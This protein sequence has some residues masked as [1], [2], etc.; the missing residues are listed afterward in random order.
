MIRV[1]ILLGV[2]FLWMAVA[3]GQFAMPAAAPVTEAVWVSEVK[4]AA[5]GGEFRMALMLKHP[6]GWHSYYQNSGGIEQSLAI[7]WALPQ[8]VSAGPIQSPVPEVKDG[9]SGKSFVHSGSPVFLIDITLPSTLRPGQTVTLG[10]EATWQICAE[11]CLNEHSSLSLVLPVGPVLVKDPAVEECFST[12]RVHQAASPAAGWS[13][14]AYS[15]GAN[16]VLRIEPGEKFSGTFTDFIPDQPFVRAA[17]DGGSI[18][19]DGKAWHLELPRAT[20]DAFKTPITQGDS[21]SGILIGPRAIAIPMTAITRPPAVP[22]PW[23]SYF[24]VLCGMALGGLL[25]NLMPCVFPVIGL[26]ILGF[27]QQSGEDRKKI[28]VHGL[29]FSL[30]VWVSFGVLSG[31]LFVARAAAGADSG[32]LGWGYQL[33]NPWVVMVLMLL[34]FVLALNLFGVFEMGI[35]ATSL[36]GSLQSKQGFAG[37]FFSGVLATV[38]ATPCSAPFLGVAL[39]AAIAL[40]GAQFFLAFAAMATG[41][42]LPYLALSIFP[43]VLGLLPRPGPWM[44]SFKQAMSFLLFATAGY[45]LWVYA[46]LIDLDHLPGPIFGLSAIAVAAWIYG[47]WNLP[48]RTRRTRGIAFLLVLGFSAGGVFLAKPPPPSAITWEPWSE[49]RVEALLEDGKPVYIDF[50]AQWCATCQANKLRAYTPQVVALMQAK[51]VVALRAD[52]TKPNPGIE[53]ALQHLG[54]TAIPVN[55]L[56]APDREP[57]ILPALL[58][59]GDLLE[60]LEKL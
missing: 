4:T 18:R 59:P 34:M 40:P 17:S 24:T 10:A 27:V 43:Q 7:Q 41:L 48:H 39:G 31:I 37:S 32:S 28:A 58:S 25:L 50:T 57:V 35:A 45:L 23:A 3:C 6:A 8:G 22:L 21:L 11:S 5:P 49:S 44:E 38:V 33:Q 30:G 15:S 60:A 12:A 36:G 47:R 16:I 42:A 53:A 2:S 19:R 55:V 1:S 56:L 29:T 54:R 26:K 51:G 46:G 20:R 52:K 14:T 13:S 9:F